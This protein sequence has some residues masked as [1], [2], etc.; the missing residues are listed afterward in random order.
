MSD[1]DRLIAEARQ[2]RR[3]FSDRFRQNGN[4]GHSIEALACAIRERALL[5]ARAAVVGRVEAGYEFHVCPGGRR[6][7]NGG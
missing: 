4:H 7:G 6:Y 5:E 1:L 2:D 3:F